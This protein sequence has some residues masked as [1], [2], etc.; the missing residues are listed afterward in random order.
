MSDTQNET[1][2]TQQETAN[3]NQETTNTEKENKQIFYNFTN[4]TSVRTDDYYKDTKKNILFDDFYGTEAKNARTE[5]ETTLSSDR[6]KNIV[7]AT[8]Y[9]KE[10]IDLSFS[11]PDWT[12]GDWVNERN[13]WQRGLYSF[14]G[15]PNWFYFKIFF[16]FQT[17]HGLLGGLLNDTDVMETTNSAGKFLKL[18]N[19]TYNKSKLLDRLIAL[20]KFASILSRIQTHTPWF[21]KSVKGLDKASYTGTEFGKEKSIELSTSGDSV[22]LRLTTLF[23]LYK[24]ACYDDINNREI[25]PENLRK[26]E[27]SVLIYSS[28][29]SFLHDSLTYDNKQ[30]KFKSVLS[31][32]GAENK[33]SVTQV[34]DNTLSYKI[35]TFKNCEFVLPE[36]GSLM[37]ND[38]NNENPFKLAD[39]SILKITYDKC[40]VHTSNELMGM[41][42]GSDG[43]YYNQYK[44][45]EEETTLDLGKIENDIL[46]NLRYKALKDLLTINTTNNLNAGDLNNKDLYFAAN[47]L[48]NAIFDSQRNLDNGTHNRRIVAGDSLY[49]NVP[50]FKKGFRKLDNLISGVVSS[51]LKAT[52]N[53]LTKKI[54]GKLTSL[55]SKVTKRG[56]MFASLHRANGIRNIGR[57]GRRF[58]SNKFKGKG[59]IGRKG[60]KNTFK[61]P[62][63]E[64]LQENYIKNKNLFNNVTIPKFERD[65]KGELNDS[66]EL[67]ETIHDKKGNTRNSKLNTNLEPFTKEIKNAFNDPSSKHKFNNVTG[68]IGKQVNDSLIL[69]DTTFDNPKYEHRKA[70]FDKQEYKPFTAAVEENKNATNGI[71]NKNNVRSTTLGKISATVAAL[72]NV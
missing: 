61:I 29:I 72:K 41:M 17:Q 37:P 21:F 12:Y 38:V 25:I 52:K 3:T 63:H 31:S 5:I 45:I 20:K 54:K 24:F 49:N 36:L 22:D 30:Q 55:L 50:I 57:K 69:N 14:G 11:F 68:N 42:F 15:E 44:A 67:N 71:M 16:K 58:D 26:F 60:N 34:F 32:S 47:E 59:S 8:E 10:D 1:T 43:F 56:A 7:N 51:A 40:Y 28:P 23:E 70:D 19:E 35:Y 48:S 6:N 53:Y 4:L 64:D 62:F 66:K 18:A 9:Y 39:G 2:N 65:I 13:V 27:M 33:E 46:L